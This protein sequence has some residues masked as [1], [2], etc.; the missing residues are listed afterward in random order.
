MV[1]RPRQRMTHGAQRAGRAHGDD[2]RPLFG[3]RELLA[4]A[5]A[6]DYVRAE[7]DPERVHACW[8]GPG[9]AIG[10][11][12]PSRRVPGSAHLVAVGTPA[13]C[14]DLLRRLVEEHGESFGSV[15]L[16]R[17]ADRHLAPAYVLQPRN[18]WEWL[19]TVDAPPRQ[20]REDGMGWLAEDAGDEIGALLT[21]WSGRHHATPGDAGVIRWAG[22]R[23]PDGGLVAVAAHTEHRAGVPHLASVATRGDARGQG[24]GGAVTAWVTRTLLE[25]GSGWVTL[26]MYSDNDVARRVYLRLGY[27]VD[28]RFTSGRLLRSTPPPPSPPR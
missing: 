14:A 22:A 7:V 13:D 25:E 3:A 20:D 24:F 18:D 4:L 17:D 1:L 12:V 2:V 6:D 21:A 5:P 26:G 11:A 8:A 16:P 23:D 9:D 10:W 15:S 27:R 28:K 19:V